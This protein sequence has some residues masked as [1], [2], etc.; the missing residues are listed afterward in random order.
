MPEQIFPATLMLKL[1]QALLLGG[2]LLVGSAQ[3][4]VLRCVDAKSGEVTYTNGRCISGESSTQIQ[5]PQSAEEIASERAS[6]SKALELSKAQMAKED[7]QRSQREAQERKEREAAEKAQARAGANL[8]NSPACRQARERHNA[9]LAEANPDP[10]TWGERSQAAQAQMEMS[11]LGSAAYQQL[12]QSRALQPNAINRPQW[13]YHYPS[14]GPPP[15][16]RPT[17]S[18]PPAKIINCNV[19][20]CY[21]N[22]GGVHPVP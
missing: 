14:Y 7:A 20:R 11:C 3:A 17:P 13:G 16:T 6:A 1:P 19:F 4:Q 8:E 9:I 18:Q 2:V 22:R 15:A 10:A 12:Q 5:A 21:D